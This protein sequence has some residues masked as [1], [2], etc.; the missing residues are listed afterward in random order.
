LLKHA[1]FGF[2]ARAGNA[3]G[4][5]CSPA[6]GCKIGRNEFDFV[7]IGGGDPLREIIPDDQVGV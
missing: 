6:L 2:W 3:G 4:S 5:A 7:F 1:P